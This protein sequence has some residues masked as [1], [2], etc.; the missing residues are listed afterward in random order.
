VATEVHCEKRISGR[1]PKACWK[2]ALS[3]TV[4]PLGSEPFRTESGWEEV[5]DG[6]RNLSETEKL[7]STYS[8]KTVTSVAARLAIY[9]G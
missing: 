3:R 6:N 5:L 1:E 8:I 2:S 4:R 7:S 9:L